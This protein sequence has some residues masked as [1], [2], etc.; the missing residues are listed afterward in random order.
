MAERRHDASHPLQVIPLG[1]LAVLAG[2]QLALGPASPV[3]LRMPGWSQ[4]CF[5]L[6]LL[7]GAVMCLASTRGEGRTFARLEMV[8][9]LITGMALIVYTFSVG[10]AV[11]GVS[12]GWFFGAVGAGC[13]Y[14]FGQVWGW[15]RRT[16]R[17]LT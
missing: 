7:C 6:M 12:L 17:E 9:M 5:A 1:G 15:L 4:L 2:L 11:G 8:G 10:G 14:R 3:V 13:V 16:G